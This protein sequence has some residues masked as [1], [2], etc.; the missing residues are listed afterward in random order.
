MPLA[1]Q[2]LVEGGDLT[3]DVL[4]R[5][6]YCEERAAYVM[7]SLTSACQVMRERETLPFLCISL[8]ALCQRLMPLPVVLQ[9]I[10]Q[11]IVH[12][13]NIDCPQA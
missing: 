2:E 7:Y 1:P 9:L 11:P 13:A 6:T 12:A 4:E 5:D 8:L 3:D 10:D